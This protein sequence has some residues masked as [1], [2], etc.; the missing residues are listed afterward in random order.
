MFLPTWHSYTGWIHAHNH[1]HHGWT[2]LQSRD[3]VWAP[4]SLEQYGSLSRW[5]QFLVRF[6]R[7][8]PGF[9][10]YYMFEI[11][12][13]KVML[14]Q[15]EM[16][17]GKIRLWWVLDDL[18]VA[19]CLAGQAW[20]AVAI[21]RHFQVNTHPVPLILATLLGPSFVGSWLIALVTYLQHTHP[22]VPWFQDLDEWNFF[23]GQ[24]LGTT[25]TKFRHGIDRLVHNVMEHTAHHVDQRIPL[26]NLPRAQEELESAV[27][28][29]PVRHHFTWRSFKYL[30]LVCQLYDFERHCWLSFDGAVTSS[31]TVSQDVL[32]RARRRQDAP[33]AEQPEQVVG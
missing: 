15:P 30:Q 22:N 25:H 17:R 19:L 12:L 23:T 9:G 11:L 27:E 3:Y 13:K 2:N 16:R 33:R 24:V 31:Q 4:L 8:W 21:A 7:W 20:A 28:Q 29:L 32:D 26:Y 1:I 5:R 10:F 18:F 14:F 6:Y